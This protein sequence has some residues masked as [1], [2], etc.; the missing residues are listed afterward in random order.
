MVQ[1]FGILSLLFMLLSGY[2]FIQQIRQGTST[3]NLTTWMISL[4]VGLVNALT[5]Y[6]VVGDNIWKSF[7]TFESL[8]IVILICGYSLYR[9]K[10]IKLNLFDIIILV[11]TVLV[12]V[13]WKF[14][15]DRWANFLVQLIILMGSIPTIRGLWYGYLREYYFAW[16]ISILAYFCV[17]VSILIDFQGDWLQLFGPILN[18]IVINGTIMLLSCKKK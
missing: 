16:G 13:V 3:P 17:L 8:T 18:G 4:L 14:T 10:F 1:L 5:F 2:F 15:S 6:R 11:I 9:G 12:G 7:I